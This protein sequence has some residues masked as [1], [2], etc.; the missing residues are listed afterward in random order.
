MRIFS[1][2]KTFGHRVTYQ[3]QWYAYAY[4]M[5]ALHKRYPF[6][7]TE[8]E[9]QQAFDDLQIVQQARPLPRWARFFVRECAPPD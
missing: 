9:V 1:R 3:Y 4:R 2:L 8:R 7:V 6:E 5:E